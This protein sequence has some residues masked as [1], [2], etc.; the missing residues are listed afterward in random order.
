MPEKVFF[1]IFNKYSPSEIEK[2]ILNNT[3]DI[4]ILANREERIIDV[5]LS[6][7]NLIDKDFLHNIEEKLREVYNLSRMSF[8]PKYKKELLCDEYFDQIVIEA[9]RMTANA[10][11]LKDSKISLLKDKEKDREK[12]TIELAHGGKR[13]LEE[14]AKFKDLLV[15]LI[16]SE[17]DF[18]PEIE[19]CG[20]VALYKNDELDII[21]TAENITKIEEH[22]KKI[23]E[24][25]KIE[26]EA[27]KESEQQEKKD[28]VYAKTNRMNFESGTGLLKIDF[29]TQ[30]R[31]FSKS[32]KK[33]D[34]DD[35][36]LIMPEDIIPI[37]EIDGDV[38]YGS[39]NFIV[40]CGKIFNISNKD[41]R[42]TNKKNMHIKITDYNSSISV[43]LIEKPGITA[44]IL[45]NIAKDDCVIISGEAVFSEFDDEIVINLDSV[46]KTKE[47]LNIDTAEKK[48]VELHLHTTMSNMDSTIKPDDIVKYAY[49]IGHKAVAV[50]DHGNV[51]AFPEVMIQK[52][53]LKLKDGES[54]KV[55]YGIEGYLLDDSDNSVFG[56]VNAKFS[57]DTFVIFDIETT[58]LTPNKCGITEIGAVKIK[59]GEIIEEFNTYVNPQMPIPEEITRLTGISDETVKD[60]PEIKEALKKF[61]DFVGNYMLIAHNA[62]FDMGFV[63]KY[64]ADC[65]YQF[66]NPYLD[67]LAMSRNI[68]KDLKNHKLNTLVEFYGIEDFTHHR[69]SDD[70]RALAVIFLNMVEQL[71][72]FG[73]STIF[74]MNELASSSEKQTYH[75]IL[76]VQNNTGLKNLYKIVSE[77]YLDYFY[78]KARIPKSVLEHYR[79][80]LIIGSACEAG[81]LFTAVVDGKKEKELCEIAEFYDYLEIQPIGNNRFLINNGSAQNEEALKDFNK[82]IIKIGEKMS[83][84]VVAT[85]DVHYLN[86]HNEISRKILLKGMKFQDADNHIP[87]YYRTTEEMLEEFTYLSKEKAYEVVVENTNKIADMI[88]DVRP[89]PKGSFT[90]KMEGAEER[91]KEI[92]YKRAG[93]LYK[94]PLPEIVEK[95]LE[96]EITAI[97]QNGFAVLYVIAVDLILKSEEQGYL[98]GS[99]GSVGSSFV[100]TLSGVTEVNPLPPHYYCKDNTCVYSSEFITDGSYG[101]G[102]DLPEKNCPVCG[103]KLAQEGQDIPFETFLGFKG[104]KAPD[105][106]L[107]FSGAV[108]SL[109][110]KYTEVLFGKENVFRAG[111]IGSLADKTAFGF[112]KKYLED[113]NINLNKAHTDWLVS[114]CVGVKR[115]TGQHPGGIIVVPREYD[116]CD[117]TPVQHPADDVKSG[118]ITT[119]FAFEF[120]HETILKL[121][122]LG[123]DVPTKYKIL[124]DMTGIDVRDLPMNDP[125]VMELFLSTKSIGVN[126]KDIYNELGTFGIPEVGTKFVRQMIIE[127]K[128]TKFA[129]LLQISGLSHGTGVWL[130]NAQELIKNNTCNL[131]EVIGIRDNIMLYLIQKGLDSS[132]AFQI[133]ESVRKGKGINS[134]WEKIMLKHDV[135]V[136]YIDSCKKIEY[137]FPKAHASAYIIG[138]MRLGWF[139]V[140]KPLEF[141]ASYFTVQ[142]EGFDAEL[143]LSG[144]DSIKRYIE[145][146]EKKGI[147]ATQKENDVMTSM[148]LVLEMNARN[149]RFLPVDIYKSSAFGY[150]I[151]DGKIRLPFSSLNGVG[152]NAAENIEVVRNEANGE[153]FSVEDICKKAKLTKTVIEVLKRNKVFGSIPETD[154]ISLF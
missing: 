14:A 69:A 133:T 27:I 81:E 136:W 90:P 105:I 63:K 122:L 36:D 12:I 151:E 134:D 88:E 72:S 99:R 56:K 84:P 20:V 45:K 38:V 150:K 2:N 104:E 62:S 21:Y 66:N 79:D 18:T 135:P 41:I 24:A 139:K 154:Q 1:D 141:Y 100:A 37:G 152:E 92:C 115:T 23:I 121:D 50:T 4:K 140:Y 128:P 86:K 6:F 144:R 51:Q 120:L 46:T 43:K 73:V 32:G 11:F 55:I 93:E 29:Q 138:A 101:S 102:Y 22:N 137:M 25:E 71:K 77:S 106:D 112:V 30:S 74:E 54:F 34:E 7:E 153:I 8:R 94:L 26:I 147:E 103:K 85:G 114:C 28:R 33:S 49:N 132:T 109:A 118:V 19:L 65:K 70:A 40:T 110:H 3:S 39:D 82:K 16:A 107:N 80:G 61:F 48:R 124:Q 119:H 130:G 126:P 52:E 129:D 96:K 57:E 75:I 13:Y 64:A 117:F 145:E 123:H 146:I 98:V 60:A 87:L 111:T 143:A 35:Y 116:I 78:K 148:L 97:I 127:T 131:S 44:E 67:T 47:I 108:Q 89:I 68:N 10:W 91:L 5:H 95:R 113:K 42:K 53:K 59:E 125:K 15:N 17:F 76:L 149:L 58:G 142:P 9:K 31:V 83:K